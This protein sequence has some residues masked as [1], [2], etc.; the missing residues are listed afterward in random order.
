LPND[1]KENGRL[2][3]VAQLMR[4][5]LKN[6]LTLAPIKDD[7]GRA[8]DLGTGTGM[9]AIEFADAHETAE[10]IG[11]DLSAIQQSWA[12]PNVKFVIDDIEEVWPY[13]ALPFD[14]IHA[15]HLAGSIRDWPRLLQQAFTCTKPGG[16]VEIHDLDLA[17]YSQDQSLRED[18][19]LQWWSNHVVNGLRKIGA[20]P[21]PGPQLES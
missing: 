9:W 12:P 5:I 13:A 20:E 21:R 19:A 17:L 10:V 2:E 7:I 14:Y 3:I 8:I 11:T 16:W 1:D 4:L 15:R 18:S 6:R